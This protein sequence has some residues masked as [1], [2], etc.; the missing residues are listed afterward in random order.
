MDPEA[1]FKGW[2]ALGNLKDV[3]GF[4]DGETWA[5]TWTIWESYAK[6]WEECSVWG[7]SQGQGPREGTNFAQL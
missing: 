4:S 7:D 2:A 3:L 6:T 5:E 1:I